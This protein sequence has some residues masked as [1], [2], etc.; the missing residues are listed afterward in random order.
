MAAWVYYPSTS[1]WW[2]ERSMMVRRG[3]CRTH[4]QEGWERGSRELQ[5]KNSN[6]SLLEDISSWKPF[7]SS[8]TARRRWKNRQHEFTMGKLPLMNLIDW[9]LW[10]GL[11]P[12]MR[13]E[14]W[15]LFTLLFA[16]F[17]Q[18]SLIVS[19]QSKYGQDKQIIKWMENWLKFQ[20]RQIVSG[21]IR[22]IP[23]LVASG[24]PPQG[25]ILA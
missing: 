16:E 7:L 9:S 2:V 4:L 5:A 11:I 3:K 15:M 14:S 6:L 23:Q 24:S 21:S 17:F 13:E 8:W 20:A 19:Y 12:C 18:R 25:Q 10:S 1:L 22:S